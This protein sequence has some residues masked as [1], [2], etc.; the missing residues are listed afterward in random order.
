MSYQWAVATHKGRLRAINQDAV[1]P[2]TAGSGEGPL[3]VVVADGMGGH[4]AGEVAS[5]IAVNETVK[6]DTD[7]EG[8]VVMAN[9]A[10][11]NEATRR[12]ELA[13]MGT[14]VTLAELNPGRVATFGHVGDSRAYLLR[15]GTLR[16]LT[17]DHTLV[18]EY[19][20][21]GRIAPE[22]IATHPQRSMLTRAVGLSP[23]VEVDVF[24]ERLQPGDRILICSDGVSSMIDD[25]SIH[26][27]L[28]ATTA[29]EAV[30]E[31][32]ERANTAG[33]HDNVTALVVD[34]K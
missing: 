26:E 25:S 15:G 9:L 13:G 14:T 5:G 27:A 30:W 8:R 23:D 1:Y 10:I 33:G 19:L 17:E 16:Q 4:A 6:S 22:D 32:V 7:I 20:Q 12:P 18:N 31:L 3:V 28:R 24:E 21:A 2:E 34:V 11:L 29:E